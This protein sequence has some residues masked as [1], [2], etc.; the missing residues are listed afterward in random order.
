MNPAQRKL[1]ARLGGLSRAAK[2]DGVEVTKPARDAFRKSFEDLVDPDRKLPE[3]ERKRRAVAA[4]HA[5]Y[6]ALSFKASMARSR[7]KNA[8]TMDNVSAL[9]DG[10]SKDVTTIRNPAA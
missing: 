8:E 10:G 4:R 9:R 2:Y 6:V 1:R 7:K 3:D 5:H